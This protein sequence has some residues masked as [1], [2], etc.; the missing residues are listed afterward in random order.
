MKPNNVGMP[1][2]NTTKK[3]TAIGPPAI[4]AKGP[5]NPAAPKPAEFAV[6]LILHIA[7]IIPAI[8]AEAINGMNNLGLLNMFAI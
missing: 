4:A 1:I 8:P 7:P 2:N 6:P 3:A 5:I